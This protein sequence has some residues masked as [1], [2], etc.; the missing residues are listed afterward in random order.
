MR[1]YGTRKKMNT[2]YFLITAPKNNLRL[3]LAL[4]LESKNYASMSTAP[5]MTVQWRYS[6]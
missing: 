6:Y 3:G 5:Y 4:K 2:I 1:S